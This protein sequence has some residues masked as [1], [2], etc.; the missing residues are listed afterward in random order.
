MSL[1]GNYSWRFR[2]YFSQDA[3]DVGRAEIFFPEKVE[4]FLDKV[5]Y[6][7][8]NS[9]VLKSLEYMTLF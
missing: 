3:T 6:R 9:L 8:A 2:K 7:G 4:W 1:T 5:S